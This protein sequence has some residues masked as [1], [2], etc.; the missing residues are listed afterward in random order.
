MM[1]RAHAMR[2]TLLLAV[3]LGLAGCISGSDRPPPPKASDDDAAQYNLQLGIGYLRQ[4]NLE[5]AKD[6]LRRALE[7]D[8]SLATAHS[9][10]GLVYERLEDRAGAEREYR[11]AV[12]LG[13]DDPDALNA[14]GSFL[15]AEPQGR[16]E[17][18]RVFERALAIPLSRKAVNRPMLYTNAATCA[19]YDDLPRAEAWL[20]RALAEDPEYRD[21][22]LQLAEVSLASGNALGARAFLE[23]YAAAQGVT[24]AGLLLGSRIET[25]LGDRPAAARYVEQLR[26]DFPTAAEVRLLDAPPVRAAE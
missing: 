15:C 8:A 16:A 19:K 4:G 14:L 5:A 22:L 20:R 25:A 18:L 2:A 7:Q 21:A 1:A 12:A 26:R 23:R 17:G 24:P 6:K 9:A 13:S 11:R 3:A 10:L